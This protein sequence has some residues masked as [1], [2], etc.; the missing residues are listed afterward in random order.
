MKEIMN[1][2]ENLCDE[3]VNNKQYQMKLSSLSKQLSDAYAEEM[4]RQGIKVKSINDNEKQSYQKTQKLGNHLYFG[5]HQTIQI[6]TTKHESKF[7]DVN[8]LTPQEEEIVKQQINDLYDWLKVNKDNMSDE[9][10][11]LNYKVYLKLKSKLE[12]VKVKSRTN[13]FKYEKPKEKEFTL[14]NM[15]QNTCNV[16]HKL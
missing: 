5:V 12:E 16:Y 4:K 7:N 14:E 1:E 15:V 10:Y 6:L 2:I 11:K 8:P 3:Y 9:A 13:E